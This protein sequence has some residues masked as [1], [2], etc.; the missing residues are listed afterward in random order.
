M[1]DTSS[2]ISEQGYRFGVDESELKELKMKLRK[3]LQELAL[4]YNSVQSTK[5]MLKIL[6]GRVENAN[7]SQE[8]KKFFFLKLKTK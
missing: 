1:A 6:E 8:I 7:L 5:S 4:T 3:D 2:V